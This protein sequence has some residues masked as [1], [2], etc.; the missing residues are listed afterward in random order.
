MAAKDNVDIFE[1]DK[2]EPLKREYDDQEELRRAIED[3]DKVG[4]LVEWAQVGEDENAIEVFRSK[5]LEKRRK[6]LEKAL[7]TAQETQNEAANLE[8]R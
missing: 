6:A 1:K 8:K 4:K 5:E 3:V 7:S 2:V